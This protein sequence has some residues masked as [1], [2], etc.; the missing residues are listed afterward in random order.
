[1]LC[2]GKTAQFRVAMFHVGQNTK[3][4]VYPKYHLM[5]Q[6]SKPTGETTLFQ[7]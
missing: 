1:M 3:A 4:Q 6:I 2:R 7:L 5:I